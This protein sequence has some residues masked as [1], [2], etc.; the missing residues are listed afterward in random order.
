MISFEDD[1]DEAFF[2]IGSEVVSSTEDVDLI[3]L[4]LLNDFSESEVYAVLAEDFLL[5]DEVYGA[6]IVIIWVELC[7]SDVFC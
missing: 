6:D 5:K 7:D 2:L 1:L 3:V 4:N